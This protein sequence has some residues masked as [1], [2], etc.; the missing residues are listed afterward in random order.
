[1]DELAALR[2]QI[3]WGAD[4]AIAEAPLDR[5][6]P[7]ARHSESAPRRQGAQLAIASAGGEAGLGETLEELRAA[8]A[9]FEGCALRHTATNLV[10]AEGDPHA[11]VAVIYD[12]PD[13]DD[14]RS[15]RPGSGE[16]GAWLDRMLASI[17]LERGRILLT[18][19]VFW[20]PPGGRPPSDREIA[21]CLPF[22]HRLLALTRPQFL[23]LLG[24]LAAKS[25]AAAGE[26]S[27]R[28]TA[29]PEFKPFALPGI[30]EPVRA[31]AIPSLTQIRREPA[32]RRQSWACLRLLKR[33]IEAEMA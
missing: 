8:V 21:A 17:G 3:E 18:P 20:R 26:S 6:Q 11:E 27:F 16:A 9:A 31:V 23:L 5:L 2:L 29:K 33:A 30:P 12:A 25:L 24:S 14:D 4:E 28:R 7:S 10:F 19:L 1:M 22:L 13:A 15:G 32:A